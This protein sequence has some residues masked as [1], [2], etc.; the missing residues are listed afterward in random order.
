MLLIWYCITLFIRQMKSDNPVIPYGQ[1]LYIWTF[2]LIWLL[3]FFEKQILFWV[4]G[5]FLFSPCNL[6]L[7]HLTHFS[8]WNN[9]F[10]LVFLN[11]CIRKVRFKFLTNN[12]FQSEYLKSK[13][14]LVFFGFI[15]EGYTLFSFPC[16]SFY[17]SLDIS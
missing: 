13:D 2:Y 8:L 4:S 6:V 5:F 17:F 12:F 10:S 9:W 3:L 14:T 16:C 7:Y 11:V 1:I 15:Y